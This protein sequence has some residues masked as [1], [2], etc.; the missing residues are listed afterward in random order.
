MQDLEETHP[1]AAAVLRDAGWTPHDVWGVYTRGTLVMGSPR[2]GEF[3]VKNVAQSPD[4]PD[5]PDDPV[6]AALWLVA[7]EPVAV[8]SEPEETPRSYDEATQ[9]Y[10]AQYPDEAPAHE[11]HE[12]TGADAG[13]ASPES[14]FAARAEGDVGGPDLQDGAFEEGGSV[15]ALLGEQDLGSE[16]LDAD[17]YESAPDEGQGGAFIFGDNLHQLRTSAIGLVVQISLGKQDAIWAE[18]GAGPDEYSQLMSAVVRDTVDGTYRGDQATYDRFVALS[19]YDN[20]A[21]RVQNAERERVTM[22][23]TADR[24]TIE[25]FDPQANWP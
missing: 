13:D 18:A 16:I 19:T 23:T 1:E 12:E 14:V 9:E 22:L 5:T 8:V 10:F 21:R 2:A 11:A 17:F 6:A 4:G 25:G 7:H 3:R 15:S 20:A 24:A